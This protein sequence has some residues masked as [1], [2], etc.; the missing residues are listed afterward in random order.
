ME[1][2]WFQIINN[3]SGIENNYIAIKQRMHKLPKKK[4]KFSSEI[5]AWNFDVLADVHFADMNK[6]GRGIKSGLGTC[7]CNDVLQCT[8]N[9]DRFRIKDSEK[10]NKERK[11]SKEEKEGKSQNQENKI[12]VTGARKGS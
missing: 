8:C 9:V 7:A 12:V 1:Y 10:G 4:E 11:E 6:N 2:Q 5:T 3:I